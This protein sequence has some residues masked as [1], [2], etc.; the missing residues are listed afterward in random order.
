M[1]NSVKVKLLAPTSVNGSAGPF[2]NEYTLV[3]LLQSVRFVRGWWHLNPN[4]SFQGPLGIERLH[5][6]KRT[7]A[8]TF[9][10]NCCRDCHDLCVLVKDALL[11]NL[12]G[13]NM[14]QPE[15]GLQYL[16][17]PIIIVSPPYCMSLKWH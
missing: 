3:S 15:G 16:N 5:F 7:V 11:A 1:H 8:R 4:H 12:E 2:V 9:G 10:V 13:L 14:F 6:V 17:S